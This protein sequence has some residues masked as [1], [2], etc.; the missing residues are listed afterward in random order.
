[1]LAGAVAR[2]GLLPS[3]PDF[4]LPLLPFAVDVYFCAVNVGSGT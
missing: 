2:V 4:F 1:M 3:V